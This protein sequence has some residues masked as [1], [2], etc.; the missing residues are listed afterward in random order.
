MEYCS[1]FKKK[2]IL[3]HATTCM[4]L[5]DT[6]LSEISHKRT[7]TVRFHLCEL[8]TRV[9]FTETES[10]MVIARGWVGREMGIYCL[11]GTEFQFCKMEDSC[12]WMVVMVAQQYECTY[13]H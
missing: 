8:P 2:E 4:N 11:M 9:K 12:G 3:T 5:E 10:R 1:A 13:C 6:I 7:G